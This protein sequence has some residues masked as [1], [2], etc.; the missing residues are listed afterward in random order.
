M[1]TAALYIR[2]STEDQAEYSPDAQK[3]LLLEYAKT[4]TIAVKNEHIFID[5]GISGRKAEKRPEFMRMITAARKKPKPFDIILVHRFDRF[6]R[7][8]EDSIVYKSLLR[9]ECDI[10]VIS[11]TEQLEDDKFSVILEAM[12]EA[13]AEYY[14]L[15][16]ADEVIKGMTEKALRG[17][18]QANPPLGYKILHSG[19]LP[20]VVSEEA[21]IIKI[22]FEKYT[23]DG[24]SCFQIAK[25][26]NLY[27]FKTR[28]NNSFERRSV[29]YIL[30]NPMYKGYIRWNQN[31]SA[32][33]TNRN[34][35]DWILV[36]GQH[37]PIISEELYD[38][39]QTRMESEGS[40]KRKARP[41][42]EYKHWLSGLLKCSNCGQSMT[43]SKVKNSRYLNFCCNGYT[44]GKCPVSNSISENM[45]MPVM[46]ETLEKV[47][48]QTYMQDTLEWFRAEKRIWKESG[49]LDLLKQQL[50]KLIVKETKI[51]SAYINGSDTLEEYE[52][53]KSNLKKE[54]KALT[55]RIKL[56][57]KTYE[58]EDK[59]TPSSHILTAYEL[60]TSDKAANQT[61]NK[62]LKAIIEKI[63]INRQE[64]TLDIYFK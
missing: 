51:K 9:K 13:M 34:P 42:T 11:I 37:K 3:R 4:N 24:L 5:E 38:L 57:E 32:T 16:L 47:L 12:L 49:E 35:S 39:A 29:E 1:Q 59:V 36:K 45:L 28:Q 50:D 18:Y 21:A 2:V 23:Y 8:R 48:G 6:S 46:R 26:L 54:Q 31:R 64:G 55:E 60:F 22:I 33:K 20:V 14:S 7:S 17:G 41:I 40:S 27:G 25:F 10:K 63:V 62:A 30:K 15:N 53:S 43:A 52:E 19:E 56:L 44:K 58:A 61:K